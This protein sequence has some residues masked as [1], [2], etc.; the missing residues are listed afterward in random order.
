MTALK[1]EREIGIES[2]LREKVLGITSAVE[3]EEKIKRLKRTDVSG[4]IRLVDGTENFYFAP[5]DLLLY[6][7]RRRSPFG[8]RRDVLLS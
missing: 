7:V 6:F 2:S 4:I 8:K 1:E 3:G 5:Q